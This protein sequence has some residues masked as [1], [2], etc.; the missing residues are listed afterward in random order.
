VINGVSG[1]IAGE[2]PK[3]WIKIALAI[4]GAAIVMLVILW[5][6]YGK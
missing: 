4:F 6:A 2:Y 1:D 5:F 3:S